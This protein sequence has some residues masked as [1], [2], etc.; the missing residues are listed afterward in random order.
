MSLGGGRLAVPFG[1]A[2]VFWGLP[3]ALVAPRPYLAAALPLLAIVGAANSIED[4]AAITLLQRTIA[5]EILTRVFGVLWGLAMG[6]VAVGSIVAPA[7]VNGLG[8][9]P[10]FVAVGA[11]LPLLALAASPRLVEIDRTLAPAPE[12]ALVARVPMFAPLSLAAKERVA[13]SLVA[14]SMAAGEVV[15][16]AGD[17]GDRFYI[18]GEGRLDVDAGGVHSALHGGDYF[19]EIALLR[20]VPRTATVTAAVDSQLYALRRDAFLATVTGHSAAHAA[21]EEVA[22]A[23]LRRAAHAPHA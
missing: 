9:R 10:A 19:G 6:A 7:L 17:P 23:R 14:T 18:V 16:R 12:L 4:V 11:I 3:I 5:D 2:L 15:I 22:E 21:G 20:D 8:S 13:S 1:L